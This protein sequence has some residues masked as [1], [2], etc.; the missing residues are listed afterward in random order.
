MNTQRRGAARHVVSIANARLEQ[1]DAILDVRSPSEYAQDHLPGAVSLPVLDDE[2][3]ARVGYL[4]KQ[5]SPFEARRLGAVL[6][7]RNI[8]RHLEERLSTHGREWRPLA[9][10]WRGGKRS[11]A[12]VHIL[13]EIGWDAQVL[14]GG[15]RAYRRQVVEQ[16]ADLPPKFRLRVVQ[17]ATGS[18]KS[19]FLAALKASGQQ[20]LDLEQLAAH[21]GSV[22]GD[23]PGQPQPTQKRFESLLLAALARLDPAL[24]VYLEGESRKIGQVQVPERL[25]E[26]MRA[27][28]CI[29]LDTA[30][31]TRVGLLLD[32]YRHFFDDPAALEAQLGHLSALHG[33][34]VIEDWKEM[35]R[36]RDWSNLVA[37]LL[38]EHYDPA[39]RKSAARNFARLADAPR[40]RVDSA[41]FES[42]AAAAEQLLHKEPVAR[43][44]ASVTA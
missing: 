17:G 5:V 23:L 15:Y 34:E 14:E 41:Q 19:R 28:D 12:L 3:R 40:L 25:I 7:A 22:L 16:L 10:C 33:R 21:R 32:E 30:L 39:Y 35:V 6:V 42:F 8:S 2:E 18:G 43:N 31:E 4:Y 26:C 13:R 20:V 1:Y 44:A 29:V 24:P 37:R 36:A 9:Y 38:V 27:S 11:A